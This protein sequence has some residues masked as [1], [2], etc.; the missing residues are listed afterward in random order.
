MTLLDSALAYA[1]RGF[2]VFP[3]KDKRPAIKDFTGAL[4]FYQ[5]A[6]NAPCMI[7]RWWT[8]HPDANIGIAPGP[9]LVI[10]DPENKT[11]LYFLARCAGV[12]A[13]ILLAHTFSVRTP[14]G[15]YH[16]YY[17][18]GVLWYNHTGRKIVDE[19][20]RHPAIDVKTWG[21][22]VVAPPSISHKGQYT[23]INDIKPSPLP[24][25]LNTLLRNTNL[26]KIDIPVSP[27][28]APS[29]D[30]WH[31]EE[32]YYE[33][34]DFWLE[35][36][37]KRRERREAYRVTS[38]ARADNEAIY[39]KT[40]QMI[41]M[42]PINKVQG[43]NRDKQQ[44]KMVAHLVRVSRRLGR[45]YI[46][47]VGTHWL[48]SQAVQF[49]TSLP[50]AIAHL[51]RRIDNALD[52]K[53]LVGPDEQD[54]V[55]AMMG[56]TLPAHMH[57]GIH[58]GGRRKTQKAYSVTRLLCALLQITF[59]KLLNTNDDFIQLT[60]GQLA[61]MTGLSKRQ[62]HRLKAQYIS[63]PALLDKNGKVMTGKDDKAIRPAN[64]ATVLEVLVEVEMGHH[65]KNGKAIPGKFLL[66]DDW[67][68]LA[69]L[70]DNTDD[71]RG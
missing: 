41:L 17:K 23:I 45:D 29:P 63:W 1:A 16:L 57:A 60:N 4:T 19:R 54:Y 42:F 6:S 62:I 11:A 49:E 61:T 64:K 66:G 36:N 14:G 22:F 5:L 65:D 20:G 33:Q 37:R 58:A 48:T 40:V 70:E 7:K 2:R 27:L 8:K 21:G 32:G 46:L 39:D 12:K 34:P 44:G 25:G 10:F 50:E 56:Q 13:K 18:T 55:N 52:S 28:P 24:F 43:L 53:C 38:L 3:V 9:D 15:G 51:E 71:Y 30:G 59:W 47:A 31:Y 35:E 69:E 26:V 68:A 67:P